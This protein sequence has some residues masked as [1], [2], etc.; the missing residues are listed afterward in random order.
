MRVQLHDELPG[1]ILAAG[2]VV[3][4]DVDGGPRRLGGRGVR[5]V[6]DD[7]RRARLHRTRGRLRAP[8]RRSDLRL[9]VD[10][11]AVHGPRRARPDHGPATGGGP[12]H[13]ERL[14]RRLR[15]QAGPL[16]PAARRDRGLDPRSAGPL[17]LHPARS[18]CARPPSG[19]RRGSSRRSAPTRTGRLTAIDFHGDFDTG[20]YASWGP[21]VANRVPVHASG[22]YVVP[23]VRAT[24]RAIY[25]NGPIGGAFRGFGV[26]QAAIAQEALLDD[27]ALQ[28][29]LDRL[30]IRRRNA[31]RAGL[32][33]GDRPGPDRERRPRRRAW[34][35][36]GRP[37]TR[38]S[39]SAAE[40]QRRRRR[41]GPAGRRHRGHVVRHRQHVAAR[42]PRP[43]GSAL[44]RDGSFVLFSG[45]QEIGQGS[46]TV[47][48]QIAADALD[49][50]AR[51]RS[52][53]SPAT[54][55]G[56]PTRA[57]R[58]RRARPSCPGMR[59]SSPPRTSSA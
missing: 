41:P 3:R 18:R 57:R 35:P 49:G 17:R 27:L 10:P 26:P 51:P 25:T 1:N 8:D 12:G 16:A 36:C 4:G 44:R 37:G 31:L 5:H 56:R 33:D 30:E 2:R 14:R 52:R 45:A 32:G 28:L 6:R 29:G 23:A 15:R 20:A 48:A 50:A 46:N 43:S 9:R 34:T 53:S 59:R 54:R 38:R 39:R 58:P 40:A 13:P 24:T 19:T 47:M 21:T 42:T 22:P 7:P 11:D 55:T